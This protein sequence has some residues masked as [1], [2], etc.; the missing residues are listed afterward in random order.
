MTK[1]L[2]QTGA[3]VLGAG[4]VGTAGE[5]I[6]VQDAIQEVVKP[7]GGFPWGGLGIGVLVVAGVAILV[8]FLSD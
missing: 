4:A 5:V 8:K 3:D 2:K 1:V 6:E 7:E